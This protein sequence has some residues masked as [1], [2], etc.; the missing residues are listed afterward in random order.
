MNTLLQR[1]ENL[2]SHHR[3]LIAVGGAAIG[4]S[5]ARAL[6]LSSRLIFTWNVFSVSALILIWLRIAVAEPAVCKRT[7]KLQDP[8]RTAI[9]LSVVLGAFASLFAVAF[10]LS[11]AKGLS[12]AKMTGHVA[13]AITTVVT[14]WCLIHTMFALRYAHIFYLRNDERADARGGSGLKFPGEAEPDYLDF[15]YFSFVL[16]MTCQVSDVQITSRRIRRLALVHGALAFVFNTAILAL[17]I[18]LVSG[19]L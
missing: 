15:A 12:A 3:L 4:F 16:G 10:L 18:N 8:N 14:S 7:A 13:M 9:F 1:L 6:H 2:D 11:S 19:L 17:S 5:A